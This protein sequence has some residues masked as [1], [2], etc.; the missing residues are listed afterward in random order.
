MLQKKIT[1]NKIIINCHNGVGLGWGIKYV[2]FWAYKTGHHI[3]AAAV[4]RRKHD[5]PILFTVFY[6]VL[7]AA[8]L[9]T[10]NFKD[11]Q[12]FFFNKKCQLFT[13]LHLTLWMTK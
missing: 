2:I 7:C 3:G 5:Y 10:H 1:L 11:L 8:T 4:Y 12:K 13:S 6:C 9:K